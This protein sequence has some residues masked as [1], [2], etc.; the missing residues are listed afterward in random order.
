MRGDISKLLELGIRAGQVSRGC[1]QALIDNLARSDVANIA[2]NQRLAVCRGHWAQADFY[3]KL[4]PISAQPK[5]LELRAHRPGVRVG[6][7]HGPMT[8]MRSTESLGQQY[9]DWSPEQLRAWITEKQLGLAV[10]DLNQTR[11]VDNDH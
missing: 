8:H 5:Q 3:G 9:L 11:P 1:A 10:D 2:D 6:L 7:V 4:R